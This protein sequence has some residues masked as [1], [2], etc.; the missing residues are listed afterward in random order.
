MK[1]SNITKPVTG[2]L[3][4]SMLTYIL[5]TFDDSSWNLG[6]SMGAAMV[7]FM[8]CYLIRMMQNKTAK[9]FLH[10]VVATF[11]GLAEFGMILYRAPLFIM[12]IIFI[13]LSIAASFSDKDFISNMNGAYIFISVVT[14]IIAFAHGTTNMTALYFIEATFIMIHYMQQTAIRQE[15]NIKIMSSYSV[16][17]EKELYSESSK[18]TFV[19]HMILYVLCLLIGLIGKIPFFRIISNKVFKIFN[20]TFDIVKSFKTGQVT[21]PE[22]D[23]DIPGGTI[24]VNEEPITPVHPAWRIIGIVGF[25]LIMIYLIF[26][27]VDRIRSARKNRVYMPDLGVT[28]EVKQIKE[29]K[30]LKKR[31]R[32]D[33]YRKAIRRIYKVRIKKGRGKR[34]DDLISKTP[35]EQ[36]SKKVSEGYE[37]SKDFVEMY[38]MARYGQDNVT[39]DDVRNMHN[40]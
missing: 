9:F 17:D 24:E 18:V 25:T 26:L 28:T 40:L 33:S 2:L 7:V 37:V 23:G 31:E 27:I 15:E 20:R 11:F 14:F 32:T 30:K 34:N 39:K 10:F 5:Y 1:L 6:I 12:W 8:L 35:H 29:E 4:W 3:F 13:I 38:E 36:R 22:D 21:Y 19:S 16:M